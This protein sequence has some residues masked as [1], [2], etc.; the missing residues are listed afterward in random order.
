MVGEY[1]MYI[2]KVFEST[3]AVKSPT[4]F[5]SSFLTCYKDI[6]NYPGYFGHAWPT[7]ST[8]IVSTFMFIRMQNIHFITWDIAKTLHTCYFKY[9]KHVWPYPL[10]MLA[11]IYR[12]P[13]CSS[14]HKSNFIPH[15]SFLRYQKDFPNLLFWVI[16]ACLAMPTKINN[17]N[18]DVHLHAK[19]KLDLS[20][21][22]FEILQRYYKLAILG[23]LDIP[24]YDK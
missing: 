22:F 17:T 20:L 13:W 4:S 2:I 9:F 11:S 18:L 21:F 15:S 5:L 19:N 3:S 6:I 1:L 23:G 14:A 16:W 10:K 7:P 12:K 24:S 8:L